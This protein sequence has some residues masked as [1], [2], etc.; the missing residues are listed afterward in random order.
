MTFVHNTI[1]PVL[2]LFLK[3]SRLISKK[4]FFYHK[5]CTIL[6]YLLLSCAV[7]CLVSC[8]FSCS[9]LSFLVSCLFSIYTSLELNQHFLPIDALRSWIQNK[10]T[11]NRWHFTHPGGYFGLLRSTR[12][13]PVIFRRQIS[14]FACVNIKIK[15]PNRS[16]AVSCV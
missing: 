1:R 6:H 13:V 12:V 5:P 15:C 9:A 8:H 4:S 3:V 16:L 14:N 10:W 2:N 7:C 11:K